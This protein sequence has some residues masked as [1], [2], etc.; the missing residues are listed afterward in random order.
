MT[1]F[2][3]SRWPFWALGI[4]EKGPCI[5]G[6][7]QDESRVMKQVERVFSLSGGCLTLRTSC[8]EIRTGRSSYPSRERRTGFVD[9]V[10]LAET[11]H[12]LGILQ[13]KHILASHHES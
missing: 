7:P 12:A 4:D 1:K 6:R 5:K 13:R 2:V 3:P 11:G 9:R 10:Q 8:R